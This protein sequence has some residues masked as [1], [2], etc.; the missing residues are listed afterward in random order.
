MPHVSKP[1]LVN[2]LATVLADSVVIKYVFQGAHW[3]VVGQ[4][5]S[6]Y[7]DLF[8][9][10][11]ADVDAAVDL[12]A[13][14]I[15]KLDAPA[16]SLLSDFLRLSNVVEMPCGQS[17]QELLKVCYEANEIIIVDVNMAFD[18]AA[19]SN[20]QGIADDLAGR[21]SAHKKFRWMLKSSLDPKYGY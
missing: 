14:D 2:A 16:P 12:I 11:Y 5:F 21:D 19:A 10:M 15:R 20:E 9:D 3:N 8:G 13:E 17:V 7:H 18:I 4:D 6:Q 1:E